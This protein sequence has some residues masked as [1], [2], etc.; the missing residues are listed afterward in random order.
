MATTHSA[1]SLGNDDHIT[2]QNT[3]P[4]HTHIP[5]IYNGVDTAFNSPKLPGGGMQECGICGEVLTD[6]NQ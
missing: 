1:T 4:Q 5:R 6:S 2:S 3:K